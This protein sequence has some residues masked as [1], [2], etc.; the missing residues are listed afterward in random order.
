MEQSII[1]AEVRKALILLEDKREEFKA[2]AKESEWLTINGIEDK[3]GFAKVHELE[4]KMVKARTAIEK[5]RKE[6]TAQ[7][8]ERKKSAIALENELVAIT[9][10]EEARLKAEKARINELKE[11][12]RLEA[13]RKAKE[14]LNR[15]VSELAKVNATHDLFDLEAMEEE[16]FVF[17]FEVKQAEYEQEKARLAKEAEERAKYEAERATFEAEKAKLE[18]EKQAIV[19]EKNRI[20]QE[21]AE[22]K[23]QAERAEE[24]KKAQE[25]SA[26]KARIETEARIKEEQEI[27]RR[28]E[29]ETERAMQGKAKFKK[30][31]IANGVTESNKEE[32][33]I[34]E[35]VLYKKISTYQA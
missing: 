34:I 12:A 1:T 25:E 8:D 32:Y 27:E 30:W 9:A 21:E 3:A 16:E 2:L 22:K 10:N 29:E 23:R 6:Y 31:L 11:Q 28:T 24:L 35:N 13:E 18:A 19:N 14:K 17:L 15:R 7:F 20:A 33:K 4:Q 5:T 26:E